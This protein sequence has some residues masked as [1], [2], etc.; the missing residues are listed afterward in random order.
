MQSPFSDAFKI[1]I[2]KRS[3]QFYSYTN[4]V[5]KQTNHE[6][7]N[8]ILPFNI[9]E[10]LKL[11]IFH[12]KLLRTYEILNSQK[13]T[14]FCFT[15]WPSSYKKC[16]FTNGHNFPNSICSSSFH[17]ESDDPQTK[18]SIWIIRNQFLCKKMVTFEVRALYLCHI[19][20]TCFKKFENN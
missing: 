1:N 8:L 11:H 10:S 17:V 15:L 20:V 2:N 19:K 13:F 4:V 14:C 7:Y 16:K 6:V 18:F 9:C 3:L 5:H 12:G